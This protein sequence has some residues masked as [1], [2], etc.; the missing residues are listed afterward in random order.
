MRLSSLVSF[1]IIFHCAIFTSAQ[2]RDSFAGLRDFTAKLSGHSPV[3]ILLLGDSHIQN[4]WFAEILRNKFQTAYGNA[5]RGASFFYDMVNTPGPEDL[6]TTASVYWPGLRMTYPQNIFREFG[7]AGYAMTSSEKGV[8][9]IE[10]QQLSD[11]FDEVTLYF[12][13]KFKPKNI[14]VY[15]DTLS[16]EQCMRYAEKNFNYKTKGETLPELAAKFNTTTT[17]LNDT[18]KR[19]GL[20]VKSGSVLKISQKQTVFNA[21]CFTSRPNFTVRVK[22]DTVRIK[23]P[24]LLHRVK[25]GFPDADKKL[26]YGYRLRKNDADGVEF[27]SIGVNGAKAS[28]YLKYPLILSQMETLRPD[29]VI[30]SLGTNEALSKDSLDE[31]RRSFKNLIQK[32]SAFSSRPNILLLGPPDNLI[33]P[34][35]RAAV[36]KVLQQL[37]HEMKIGFY[38]QYEASGGAGTFS[39]GQKT[40]DASDDRVHYLKKGYHKLAEN[41]W[42]DWCRQL[43]GC[44]KTADK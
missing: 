27:S 25:M 18:N 15:T 5:G 23:L 41:L 38:S 44:T 36:E 26:L 31:I 1:C 28:D 8:L 11:D 35:R 43:P 12:S 17:A 16:L 3:H 4:G 34:E 24:E 32:L 9:Q 6:K 30:L 37:A 21:D 14:A 39:A 42:N 19:Q 20:M 7:L 2:N 13:P 10:S 22:S 40:G 29:L 33:A